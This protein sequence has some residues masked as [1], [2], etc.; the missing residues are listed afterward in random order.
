MCFPIRG[1]APLVF[2]IM[3]TPFEFRQTQGMRDDPGLAGSSIVRARIRTKNGRFSGALHF[4]DFLRPIRGAAPP[5]FWKFEEPLLLCFPVR[6][7]APLVFPY[8]D[9]V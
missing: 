3:E 9:A 4:P 8:G 7:A 1:A 2:F 6:G 5:V